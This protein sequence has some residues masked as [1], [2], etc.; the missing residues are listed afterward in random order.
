[1]MDMQV[2]IEDAA[3]LIRSE[4]RKKAYEGVESLWRIGDVVL[5]LHDTA[6]PGQWRSTLNRLACLAGLH[7]KYLDDAA[8]AARAFPSRARRELLTRFEAYSM[9]LSPS[10]VIELAR[11][12]PVR[13]IRGVE[14]LLHSSLSTRE[15]R[16]Y[17]RGG[18]VC[19][20]RDRVDREHSIASDAR[21]VDTRTSSANGRTNSGTV[22]ETNKHLGIRVDGR[23][24]R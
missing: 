1:V 9:P 19:T 5:W 3:H 22:A 16:N 6:S 21:D 15:L 23:A 12:N 8:L 14:A 17:L 4:Q 24:P 7:P 10:H 11:T 20:P 13:R 2:A 18:G